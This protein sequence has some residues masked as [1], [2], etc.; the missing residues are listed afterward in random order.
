MD[1]KYSV[2]VNSCTAALHLAI[3]ALGIGVGDEIITTP[4]TF[5]STAEVVINQRA[6]PVFVDV[7]ENTYN[8]DPSKIEEKITNKTKAIIPVHYAGHAC[9]MDEIMDIAK[10]ND[11]FVIEDAAHALGTK[12]KG[13]EVG[14][15]GDATCFSF[16]ATKNITTAEGG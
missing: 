11:L 6:T 4:F 9:E 13:K 5:A 16:Y 3:A 10:E 14:S 7:E 8:I 12:Y 15:I 2:A 1:S